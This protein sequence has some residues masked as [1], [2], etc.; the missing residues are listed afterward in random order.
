M[1]K[2]GE[3]YS[4]SGAFCGGESGGRGYSW[5]RLRQRSRAWREEKTWKKTRKEGPLFPYCP[6]LVRTIGD[7]VGE[8]SLGTPY[9]QKKKISG[10]DQQ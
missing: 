4:A 9:H 5:G 10:K 7:N 6:V 8:T 3:G 1:V 2:G